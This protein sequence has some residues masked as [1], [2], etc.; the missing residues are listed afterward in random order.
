ML[1]QRTVQK[2]LVYSG[3]F[4]LVVVMFGVAGIQAKANQTGDLIAEGKQIFRYDTFGDE[5]FWGGQLQL[6]QAIQGAAAAT[7]DS[8][9]RRKC[10]G[11]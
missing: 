9:T 10:S 6:H 3:V 8:S 1:N 11:S 7:R 2:M 5:D 4:L